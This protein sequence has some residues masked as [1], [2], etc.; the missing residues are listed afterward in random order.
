M[1][2]GQKEQ[3][4]E[5]SYKLCNSDNCLTQFWKYLNGLTKFLKLYIVLE[6][7]DDSNL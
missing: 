1:F 2:L 6:F 3:S 5:E 7:D 4:F